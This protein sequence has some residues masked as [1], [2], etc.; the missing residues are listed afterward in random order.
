L[1]SQ[2]RR[3]KKKTFPWP[4]ASKK[5]KEL[6]HRYWGIMTR[7]VAGLLRNVADSLDIPQAMLL[8]LLQS[9]P[10]QEE[11]RLIER[12]ER[13]TS[14][15]GSLADHQPPSPKVLL[16]VGRTQGVKTNTSAAY[17]W[18]Q[19]VLK[20]FHFREVRGINN[21]TL[22]L[23]TPPRVIADLCGNT[24]GSTNKAQL[25]DHARV[26]ARLVQAGNSVQRRLHAVR[27]ADAHATSTQRIAS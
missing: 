25:Q 11:A 27:H 17:E 10:S 18:N 8:S 22:L 24:A 20:M 13:K 15:P 21:R 1:G 12:I 3:H 16:S 23:T 2:T 19:P 4:K 5:E 26:L 7:V 9:D 6:A 14:N